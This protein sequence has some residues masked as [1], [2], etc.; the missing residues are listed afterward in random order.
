MHI[1]LDNVTLKIFTTTVT[2]GHKGKIVF[3]DAQ[4]I[5]VSFGCFDDTKSAMSFKCDIVELLR[6]E[7]R[8]QDLGGREGQVQYY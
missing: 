4:L 8:N 7:D 6:W 1:H 2:K 3:L 5:F